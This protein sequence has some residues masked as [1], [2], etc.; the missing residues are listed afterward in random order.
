[1]LSIA[2]ASLLKLTKNKYLNRCKNT[3]RKT[4]QLNYLLYVVDVVAD[5]ECPLLREMLNDPTQH[6]PTVMSF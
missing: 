1:M 6:V 4:N 3:K 5:I 2:A